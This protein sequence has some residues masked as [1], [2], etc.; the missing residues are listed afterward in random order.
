MAN[1]LI[2]TQSFQIQFGDNEGIRYEKVCTTRINENLKN[3]I[4]GVEMIVSLI[5]RGHRVEEIHSK[6]L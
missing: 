5:F 3:Y 2:N 4:D 6:K 1:F